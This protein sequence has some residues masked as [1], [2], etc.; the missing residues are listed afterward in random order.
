[1]ESEPKPRTEISPLNAI[2]VETA[3]SR[4]PVH[5]LARKGNIKIEV[6]EENELG[7]STTKWKVSYNSEYGQPGPLAYK[8]D[9]LI[10]NR[11]I[12]EAARPI[13]R[14]IKLGS[15]SDICRELNLSDSGKNRA[16]I[17][18]SLYQNAFS[19]ITAK[20]RYRQGDGTERTL[21]AG[22]TRYS[23][24]LT[25]EKLPDG[26]TAD[27]VYIVL[28]DVFIRILNGAMTRPLDYDY[29]KSLPPAPQRFYEILSYQMYAA[30]RYDRARAKLTYSEFCTH[31]PQTR[32]FEFNGVKK[33]MYKI[34]TEH[35][36]SGYISKVDYQQTTDSDGQPD[37]IMLYMPGPKAS[38]EFRA[39]TKRGGPTVLE[40][41]HPSLES[42]PD[43]TAAEPPSPLE[44][45]LIG[46]GVTPVMAAELVRQH[47]EETVRAQLEYLDWRLGGKKAEKIAD[48]A[49][50]LVSAIKTGHAAPKGYVSKAERERQAEAAKQQQQ[51]EA[52]KRRR[53]Q[54]QEARERAERQ[55]IDA[56]WESLT[57]EQQAELQARADAQTDSEQLAKETG[58]LKSLGQTIR[59][60]DYIRQILRDQGKL[61]SPEA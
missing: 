57:K 15:L 11:R 17:K 42:S 39:F 54:E 9:T 19:G 48:P 25:G 6:N 50:W 30:L 21:E 14:I 52:D 58:P 51:A 33:Q 45:R 53:K 13:P 44:A 18:R 47:G 31:A 32:Y 55:A 59:R 2:R 23:V 5:R 3:L 43:L 61:P 29:L 20:T 26:R 60:H 56:H 34:H 4:Y 38:A 16:D 35:R 27:G 22:F 49:G 41:E 36:K 37:W 10:I 46:H 24:I 8:L 1:M 28:N 12:E 7:E 40:M